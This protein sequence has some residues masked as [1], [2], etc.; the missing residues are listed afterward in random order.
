MTRFAALT[1][2][3]ARELRSEL[4]RLH[5]APP[6][7]SGTVGCAPGV[8]GAESCPCQALV[9]APPA[10]FEPLPAGA[11][12][13]TAGL[14]RGRGQTHADHHEGPPAGFP[15][16]TSNVP[17][18]SERAGHTSRDAC[19][20]HPGATACFLGP[21]RR[22]DRGQNDTQRALRTARRPDGGTT[23]RRRGGG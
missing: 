1:D 20:R 19:C 23:P 16:P 11:A 12:V 5:A 10:F 4:I 6:H 2:G 14:T 21:R 8:E 13:A 3:V 15:R 18:T 7:V 22:V 17:T 9:R